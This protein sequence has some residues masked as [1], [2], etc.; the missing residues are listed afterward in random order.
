[1]WPG[2]C[3]SHVVR[4]LHQSRG[5]EPASVITLPS[6]P[7][8]A[9]PRRLCQQLAHEFTFFNLEAP[10]LDELL[11]PPEP[12]HCLVLVGGRLSDQQPATLSRRLQY[13]DRRA[14]GW[15]RLQDMTVGRSNGC[16][17][18]AL[19]SH[20]YVL[21]G[22]GNNVVGPYHT[23]VYDLASRKMEERAG[24]PRY[25]RACAGVACDG[26]VYSLGG[27]N[28]DRAAVADV[29]AYNPYTD[30]WVPG[31]PLPSALGV[32]AA[33]EHQGGIYA[34]GGCR[35]SPTFVS[36]ALS[37]MDPRTRAWS[38]LA[39]MPTAAF[40]VGAAVVG[41]RMYVPGGCTSSGPSSSLQCYDIAAGRWDT[42][43]APLSV[44]RSACGVAALQGEVW[45][46]GGKTVMLGGG[47]ALASV[48]VYSPRL[49]SWRAGEVL[50]HSWETGVCSVVQC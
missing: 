27:I 13:Y 30:S 29:C 46:L 36:A 10:Q 22:E 42:S 33:A 14:G 6:P 7:P 28:S 21:G 34:C 20:L 5:Q 2:A 15:G 45:A 12:E 31:P 17:A 39:T 4:G 50:P 40:A 8:L 41:S 48:E 3:I 19:G 43:C 35:R 24:P 9:H 25:V 49:N 37:M 44:T 11:R 1:M 18:A 23:T 47:T 32:L 26:L 38:C 16:A